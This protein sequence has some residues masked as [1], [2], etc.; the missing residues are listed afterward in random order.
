MKFMD[1]LLTPPKHSAFF[2][3]KPPIKPIHMNIAT[4]QLSRLFCFRTGPGN[5]FLQPS[6]QKKEQ[7]T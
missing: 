5:I 3:S 1:D 4:L 6:D 2:Y 7:F